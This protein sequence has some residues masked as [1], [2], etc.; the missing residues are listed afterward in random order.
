MEVLFLD[1]NPDHTLVLNVLL[2]LRTSFDF[3]SLSTQIEKQMLSGYRVAYVKSKKEVLAVAGFYIGE[4]LA[5]GKHLYIDDLVVNTKHR[6]SG[7]GHFFIDWLKDFA[8]EN[9][10]QQIH[11]DSGVQRFPAHKFY[12]REGFNIASHH[13]SITELSS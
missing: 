3:D 12:L 7:V 4:K 6:S 1:K 10:C 9:E 5:W 13:F 2:Q 11:L 8:L